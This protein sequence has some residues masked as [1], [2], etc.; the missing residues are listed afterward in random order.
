MNAN[1]KQ[2]FEKTTVWYLRVKQFSAFK[3]RY[4]EN[5]Y[6]IE[7]ILGRL[8]LSAFSLVICFQYVFFFFE[9]R[10]TEFFSSLKNIKIKRNN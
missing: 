2:I 7:T 1:S 8:H 3:A 4:Y 5:D 10:F 9:K 6:I